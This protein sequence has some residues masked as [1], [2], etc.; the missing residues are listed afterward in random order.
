[1]NFF[2]FFI[3]TDLKSYTSAACHSFIPSNT[4]TYPSVTLLP[5]LILCWTYR[6]CPPCVIACVAFPCLQ[7]FFVPLFFHPYLHVSPSSFISF[8][9]SV[10][11]L[12]I[13][14]SITF[15]SVLPSS[16]AKLGSSF[17]SLQSQ[18]DS[19]R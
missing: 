1:M 17:C 15:L 2:Q 11:D 16:S 8:S 19:I 5:C 14:I 12:G 18:L 9:L 13:S 10:S 6:F 7:F 4:S 3:F